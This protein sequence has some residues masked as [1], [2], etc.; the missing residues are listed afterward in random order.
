MLKKWFNSLY[1]TQQGYIILGLIMLTIAFI[2]H[3]LGIIK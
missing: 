1:P 2:L 3:L